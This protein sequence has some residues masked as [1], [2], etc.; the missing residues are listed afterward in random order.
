MKENVGEIYKAS[1]GVFFRRASFLLHFAA[2]L[3]LFI[4]IGY[5]FTAGED[6]KTGKFLGTFQLCTNSIFV[7]GTL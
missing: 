6:P 7:K 1:R 4:I 2:S 3:Y 5:D